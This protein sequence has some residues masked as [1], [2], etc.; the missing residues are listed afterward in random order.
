VFPTSDL[1]PSNILVNVDKR[2][3]LP[4]RLLD[5]SNTRVNDPEISMYSVKS[6]KNTLAASIAAES[7]VSPAS[8]RAPLKN[9]L[10]SSDK[11]IVSINDL[12]AVYN[13]VKLSE[14]LMLP[15][16]DLMGV[17]VLVKESERPELPMRF[18]VPS[19]N[20]ANES[21][22]TESAV[23][24]LAPPKYRENDSESPQFPIMLL[25]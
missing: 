7:T 11:P 1:A 2:P 23:N 15:T 24:V 3:I 13:P 8:D 6:L 19:K 17:K 4:K 10:K 20:L 22:K 18:L 21:V 12:T 14:R 9:R 25:P 5:P 16:I